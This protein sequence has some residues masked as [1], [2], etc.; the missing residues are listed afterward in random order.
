MM[1]EITPSR[2]VIKL[3]PIYA[4]TDSAKNIASKGKKMATTRNPSAFEL[5]PE[6]VQTEIICRLA[7]KSRSN[8]RNLLAAIPVRGVARAAAVP[9]VYK[10]LNLHRLTIN[11]RATRTRYHDV[12]DRC[13]ASG[14]LQAHY[15][16]GIMEYFH[17]NNRT[18]GLQH[19]QISAEGSYKK[20]VYLYGIIQ[21]CSGE[22]AIGQAMID[23]LG[24]MENKARVDKCWR[25]IKES[26]H[27]VRVLR[28]QSYTA[29]YLSTRATITCHRDKIEERCNTCFY[30]K[31]I[32]KFVF[33]M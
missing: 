20:A 13:L 2:I 11:P 1:N 31:Q 27:G 14:N 9:I 15:V 18:G 3:L 10:I 32:T 24:W 22:P 17:N 4:I 23:S 21:L 26:L 12:M 7:K 5:L 25:K 16:R 30:Y 6:D 28:L 29:T 33:M 19:L 8:V